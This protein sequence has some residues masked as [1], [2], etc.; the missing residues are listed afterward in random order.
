MAGVGRC[1][2]LTV[3]SRLTFSPSNSF[4]HLVLSLFSSLTFSLSL[5]SLSGGTVRASDATRAREHIYTYIYK[6]MDNIYVCMNI[7]ICTATSALERRLDNE[8]F[9]LLRLSHL[10][11]H[12]IFVPLSSRVPKGPFVCKSR[13]LPQRTCREVNVNHHA[14]TRERERE[15]ER[16]RG[17]REGK[18]SS[19]ATRQR[20][21]PLFPGHYQHIP[22]VNFEPFC[23]RFLGA[24]HHLRL[25]LS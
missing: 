13:E 14:T 1:S 22:S 20:S 2:S 3:P 5:S 12:L 7:C 9:R 25:F 21:P 8:T 16:R 17:G 11:S 23:L 4:D 15:S 18:E 24:W 6:Y 10:I 19:S